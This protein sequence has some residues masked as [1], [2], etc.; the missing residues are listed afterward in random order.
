MKKSILILTILFCTAFI[1]NAQDSISNSKKLNYVSLT[2]GTLNPVVNKIN[3]L[4]LPSE[5]IKSEFPTISIGYSMQHKKTSYGLGYTFINAETN[6]YADGQQYIIS[7]MYVTI[8]LQYNYV[9]KSYFQLFSGAS[10]GF[11]LVSVTPAFNT[12]PV[13]DFPRFNNSFGH[14][15]LIGSALVFNKGKA[16]I[17]ITNSIGYGYK[18]IV[19]VGVIVKTN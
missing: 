4:G 8:D 17:G 9:S 16:K 7:A 2:L 10:T 14:V 6:K 3:N 13:T 12:K 15:D 18:G 19:R 5:E 1:S 11:G